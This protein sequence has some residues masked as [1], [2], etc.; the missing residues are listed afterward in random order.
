MNRIP[1]AVPI[2]Y[3]ELRQALQ[4][5]ELRDFTIKA[6]FSPSP[7]RRPEHSTTIRSPS[8]VVHASPTSPVFMYFGKKFHRSN[9]LRLGD[10][11]T[12]AVVLK[13]KC[14]NVIRERR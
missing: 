12:V 8:M 9:T 6:Q 3:P 10:P 7:K 13:D 1:R 11:I 5:I 2:P 4:T 14:G